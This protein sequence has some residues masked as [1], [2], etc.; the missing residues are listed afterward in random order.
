LSAVEL[1]DPGPRILTVIDEFAN[2]ADALPNSERKELWRYARMVAAEGRKAGIHLALALQDPTHKSLD[3]RIRRNCL[4]IS[5]RVKDG[6]ASRVILGAGGAE[7]LPPRQFLTVMDR[8]IQGVAF[9]PSD[10]EIRSFLAARPVAA[11]PAPDWLDGETTIPQETRVIDPNEQEIA[12]M[13]TAGHSLREIQ[14]Q[15][16]GYAGGAAYEAVKR[17]QARLAREG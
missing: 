10:Q 4:P 2:L 12:N 15:I 11:Y 16:F 7:R 3:L 13:L 14:Q 8:L 1:S 17:V 9:A 5:F 6:D